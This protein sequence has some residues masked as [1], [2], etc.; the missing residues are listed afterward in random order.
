MN[1]HN[2]EPVDAVIP[3]V[4]GAE[5]AHKARLDAYLKSLGGERPQTAAPTRF[6]NAGEL[7]YCVSSLLRFAPWI[8]TI[9][10]VTDSQTPAFM[11]KLENT[12]FAGRIKIVEH[13]AIFTGFEKYLPTFNSSSILSVLWRIPDLA[14]NF[15]FL[16]D[17]FIIIRPVS[18]EDFFRADKVVLR[19]KWHLFSDATFI[20]CFLKTIRERLKGKK[21]GFGYIAA[22]ELSA[23]LLE[24]KKHYFQVTHNPHP[25][26]K[27]LQQNYFGKNPDV[28]ESNVSFRLR[29]PEQF[30]IE[31]LSAHL[32][33]K[34]NRAVF[35][36][37]LKALMLKPASNSATRLKKKMT[38]ADDD[39]NIAFVC[40]Q[41]LEMGNRA[42]Q[43]EI[44]R[45]LDKRVGL[46]WIV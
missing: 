45:W 34:E 21:K 26:H 33:I 28:L 43:E 31:A 15:L 5:P 30:I 22:Q 13:K 7:D 36:N 37:Q 44:I 12:P 35:D 19:G 32:S 18:S 42:A 11:K 46:S 41:S 4:D 10:I 1:A 39:E 24:F 27:S 9:H 40:V 14:E 17:D 38:Q 23:K 6:H 3:W 29:A 20:R 2:Q 8:R 25:M 16:N